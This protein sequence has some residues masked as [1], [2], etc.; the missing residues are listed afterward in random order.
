MYRSK[1]VCLQSF[2]WDLLVHVCHGVVVFLLLGIYIQVICMLCRGIDQLSPFIN[3][4]LVPG[5]LRHPNYPP[6]WIEVG[7]GVELHDQLIIALGEILSN[8]FI[9]STC[10]KAVIHSR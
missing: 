6:I 4:G 3:C 8:E 1:L 7:S 5:T 2:V 10:L 9:N